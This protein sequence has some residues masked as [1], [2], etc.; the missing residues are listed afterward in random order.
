MADVTVAQFAD[1]LKVPVDKLLL[2]LDEAGIK[3][4]GSDDTI[5]EDAKLD[6][7]THLRQ[8]HGRSPRRQAVPPQCVQHDR[9]SGP[10]GQGNA[11]GDQRGCSGAVKVLAQPR[12]AMAR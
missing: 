11:G 5:S 1:V 6:L 3:V 12:G 4:K 9:R 7:L 10:G 8:S 2:Q